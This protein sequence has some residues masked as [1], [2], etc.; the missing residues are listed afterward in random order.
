MAGGESTW[1]SH[2]VTSLDESPT[3][4]QAVVSG[5]EGGIS[6]ALASFIAQTVQ[7]ALAAE[8]SAHS[9]LPVLMTLPQSTVVEV[10][11]SLVPVSMASSCFRGV[12][13]SLGSW[14]SNFLAAGT[15]LSQQGSPAFSLDIMVVPSFVSTFANPSMLASVSSPSVYSL[16]NGVTCDVAD[17]SAVLAS[18]LLDQPFIVGPGFSPIPV[19][20]VAQIVA[21]KYIDLSQ[22]TL[23]LAGHPDRQLVA[24]VLNG[25]QHG[26]C[27]GFQPARRLKPAKKNKPS[28]FQNP[29]VIDDYLATEVAR[30]RVTGPFP[31][32]PLPNL[33]VSSFGVIPQKGQ[34]GK[35]CLIVDLS[36]PHGSSVNDGI[37][38][39]EFSMHY[40]HLDQII[41]MIAKHGPGAL[42]AKFD[43]EAAYR[44]IAVHPDDRYLL[45]MKWRGQ[46]FVDL[47]LPFGLRS[48]P[49]NFNSLADLVE[50]FLQNKYRVLDLMH[51]LDD[52]ITAS[53][54]DSLQ[55]SQNLQTSLAICHSLGLPLHPNSAL[56]HPLVW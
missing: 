6:P 3:T 25:L 51:Y 48:A 20:L 15:G 23:D 38:L 43:V 5:G 29:K 9:S 2:T 11:N 34:P 16:Q 7:A 22:F 56:A 54:A 46:F 17:R 18:P 19:K 1:A 36:S 24:Y 39:D 10:P 35:W 40:I 4:S 52:F 13:S 30:G 33:Q 27:L 50:W 49:Y 41:N 55:C 12:P 14:A 26:V 44:N 21:D 32:P 28:A 8:W 37:D 45:G 42:M 31:S 53:L 47:A